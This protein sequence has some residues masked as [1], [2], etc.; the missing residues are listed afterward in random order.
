[1]HDRSMYVIYQRAVSLPTSKYCLINP[2]KFNQLTYHPS[3]LGGGVEGED[4]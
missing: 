4:G 1:M 3:T 2:L